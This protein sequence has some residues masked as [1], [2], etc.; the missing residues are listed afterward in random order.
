MQPK[1]SERSVKQCSNTMREFDRKI[2]LGYGNKEGIAKEYGFHHEQG[3]HSVASTLV[4]V[5]RNSELR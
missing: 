1:A 3:V 5:S 2:V 4:D